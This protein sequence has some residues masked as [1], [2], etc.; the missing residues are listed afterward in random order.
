MKIIVKNLAIEYDDIG[1]GKEI[2]MLHGWGT[3]MHSFNP[4][5]RKLSGYRIIRLDLPG[6]G[7]SEIKKKWNLSDYVNFVKDFLSKLDLRPSIIIGHS[8]GGRIIIKGVG[9]GIFNPEKIV[10][11][12]PAGVSSFNLKIFLIKIFS[13]FFKFILF[14]PPLVFWK[15]SIRKNFYKHIKSEYMDNPDMK[16]TFSAVVSENLTSYAKNI[17][18]KTIL[19]W[20]EKDQITPLSDGKFL[21]KVLSNSKLEIVEN[22]GHFSFVEDPDRVA[23]LIN[24]F[25]M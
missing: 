19:I 21:N 20:G 9:S 3:D 10:L 5:I 25:I 2:L 18:Q 1:F 22:T 6:F 12:S 8:F 24:D 16:D 23:R 14:V 4:L 15:N 13:K 11:I 17:K 7:S